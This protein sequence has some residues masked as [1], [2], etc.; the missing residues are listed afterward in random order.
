M[1]SVDLAG[2][3]LSGGCGGGG[4]SRGF[5]LGD[6]VGALDECL[7]KGARIVLVRADPKTLETSCSHEVPLAAVGVC[8]VGVLLLLGSVVVCVDLYL[9]VGGFSLSSPLGLLVSGVGASVVG[10]GSPVAGS[11]GLSV[12]GSVGLFA[13]GSV[14]SASE[15]ALALE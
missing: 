12:V 14:G 1:V 13:V 4:V 9:L 15:S 8:R 2:G 6:A 10:V 5:G 11:A 7:S 3:A